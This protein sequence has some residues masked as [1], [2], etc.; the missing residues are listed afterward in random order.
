MICAARKG[1]LTLSDC[2]NPAMTTCSNCGRPMC[3]AHLSMQSGFTM[4]LDCAATAGTTDPNQQQQTTNQPDEY[5]DVWAH[6][7]RDSYYSSTGYR[8]V[9][10]TTYYDSHDSRSFADRQRDWGEDEVDRGGFGAS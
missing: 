6:R 1:F 7:Y 8:P 3:T 2:G 9:Y 10:G 4:C 5:D